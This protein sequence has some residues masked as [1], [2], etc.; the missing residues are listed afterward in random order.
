[1]NEQKVLILSASPYD[2]KDD[3]T[4]KQ[5]KG[6]TLWVLPLNSSDTYTNGIKP[7]KY[8]LDLEKFESVFNKEVLPAFATM[9]F[10]FD[11]S[12]SKVIPS[13]FNEFVSFEVGDLVG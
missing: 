11:F 1:M 10:E 8:S 12:R 6:I 4:G 2:F 5:V 3:R 7:V 13:Q 9:Q